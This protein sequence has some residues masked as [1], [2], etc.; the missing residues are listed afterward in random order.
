MFESEIYFPLGG[1]NYF[2]TRFSLFVSKMKSFLRCVASSVVT[3]SSYARLVRK[4]EKFQ[5]NSPVTW[6]QRTFNPFVVGR[7]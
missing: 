7:P 3:A 6:G 4:P 5:G 2:E 1:K